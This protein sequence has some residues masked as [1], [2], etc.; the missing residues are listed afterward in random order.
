MS[1]RLGIKAFM[2]SIIFFLGPIDPINP[3]HCSGLN[4]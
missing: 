3:I 1:P 4:L 2:L